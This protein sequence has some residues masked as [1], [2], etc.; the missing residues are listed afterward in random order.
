[1]HRLVSASLFVLAA[2]TQG[3]GGPRSET[4][5]AAPSAHTPL[6]RTRIA[7]H[8][9][10]RLDA[11]PAIWR[12]LHAALPAAVRQREG[13][14]LDPAAGQPYPALPPGSY[15]CRTLR[16]RP[17]GGGSARL[18]R[19]GKPGFCYVSPAAEP[20]AEAPL[21]LSKQTGT[22]IIAGYLFAD[23]QRLVFLGASQRGAGDNSIGYG[24][25]I[26]RD[27]VGLVERFGAF[28]WRLVVARAGGVDLYEL[29]PVP[30]DAQP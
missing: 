29:T 18:Q 19:G 21:G 22:D 14:L 12:K 5:G 16:L 25:A 6:W 15:R 9:L 20:G 23:D 27:L 13:A 3:G 1:M 26:E 8:D 28:R 2:C 30:A 17:D 10:A 7:P 11:L 24:T 4:A